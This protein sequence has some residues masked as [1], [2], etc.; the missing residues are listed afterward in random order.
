MM[1]QINSFAWGKNGHTIVLS[2]AYRNLDPAV[3]EIFQKYLNGLSIDEA[4]NWMDEI[5]GDSRF[6]Y[7]RKLHYINLNKGENYNQGSND[8]IVAELQR[9]I[10]VLKNPKGVSDSTMRINL[11]ELYHLVADIS[12]PYHTIGEER[13]AMIIEF[14]LM[15]RQQISILFGIQKLLNIVI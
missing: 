14:N 1:L 15:V 4:A 6:D 7:L 13:G 10:G 3:K 8:N 12:M 5:K 2:I 9:I 11:L